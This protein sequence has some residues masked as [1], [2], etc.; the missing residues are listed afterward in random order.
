MAGV[1][2]RREAFFLPGGV[3][4]EGRFCL[5]TRAP[6]CRGTLVFAHPFAEEMNKS[7]RMVALAAGA[8]AACGWS[9]L[10]IDFTGCGDSGGD[11]EDASWAAWTADL[12]DAW[13]WASANL[14]GPL[15]VWGLR[16]GALVISDWLRASGV[17]APL[18]LWQPVSNG[19]QHLNQ[20]L[21]LKAA[22]EMLADAD[23]KASMDLIRSSLQAGHA[24][25][26]AGYRLPAALAGGMETSSLSLPPGFGAPVALF[27]LGPPERTE[28]SPALR[29]LTERWSGANVS[30]RA[31]CVAGPAFWQTQEIELCPALIDASVA[32]LG[33]LA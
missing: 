30:V 5:L 26:V 1:I 9:T 13:C 28:L 20:F 8:F 33:D 14:P 17:V 10:Q 32:A 12:H 6:V 18:L 22:G 3:T 24:V 25:D 15:A 21:R 19:R 29:V 11:F 4:R 7:R 23:A 2:P 31:T 16:G 27:E